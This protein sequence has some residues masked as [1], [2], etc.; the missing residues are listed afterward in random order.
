MLKS[1]TEELAFTAV[2]DWAIGGPQEQ[3]HMKKN[4]SPLPERV[5]DEVIM[6]WEMLL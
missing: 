5:L 2:S 3:K 4:Q 6:A 1:E